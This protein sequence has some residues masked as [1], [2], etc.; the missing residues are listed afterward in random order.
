MVY[1]G[2]EVRR[3]LDFDLDRQREVPFG[4]GIIPVLANLDELLCCGAEVWPEGLP[5]GCR[6]IRSLTISDGGDLYDTG[7]GPREEPF[8]ASLP[9]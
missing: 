8:A 7:G 5:V 4:F 6:N 9:F 2:C 3:V 1:I